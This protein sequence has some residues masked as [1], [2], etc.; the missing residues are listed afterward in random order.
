MFG[1][2]ADLMAANRIDGVAG[3]LAGWMR[4]PQKG[5]VLG[6]RDGY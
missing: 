3:A 4:I 6:M 1:L 2:V 5:T